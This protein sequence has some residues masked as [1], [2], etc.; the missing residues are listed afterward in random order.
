M[1]QPDKIYVINEHMNEFGHEF[2]FDKVEILDHE[3]NWKKGLFR[4]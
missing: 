4:K 2:Q 1:D 3:C